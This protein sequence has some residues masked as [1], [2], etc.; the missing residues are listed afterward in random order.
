MG[1]VDPSVAAL[2]DAAIDSLTGISVQLPLPLEA[3]PASVAPGVWR[4]PDNMQIDADERARV[5][6]ES[7]S[8]ANR[9]VEDVASQGISQPQSIEYFIQ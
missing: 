7:R 8:F 2:A 6:A 3:P 1:S 9:C 5:I 4:I